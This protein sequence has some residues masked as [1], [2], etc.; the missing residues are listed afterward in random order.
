VE[1]TVTR[2]M[3]AVKADRAMKAD[4]AIRR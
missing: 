4:R 1:T 3:R 2:M